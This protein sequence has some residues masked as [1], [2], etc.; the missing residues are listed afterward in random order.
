[1]GICNSKIGNFQ[2]E[3]WDLIKFCDFYFG[4]SGLSSLGSVIFWNVEILK[5]GMK[6][7]IEFWS[8]Y[9]ENF[10]YFFQIWGFSSLEFGGFRKS[11]AWYSGNREFL[12]SIDFILRDWGF[13]SRG[14]LY[15]EFLRIRLFSWD[16]ICHQK[17]TFG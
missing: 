8:V 14:C 17:T 12:K 5:P 1:M 3:N 2:R 16:R 11:G 4:D 10:G 13:L 6:D 9:L 7:F 15:P